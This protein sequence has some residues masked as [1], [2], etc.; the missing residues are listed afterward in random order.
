[1]PDPRE[2][3][4]LLATKSIDPAT[5]FGGEPEITPADVAAMLAP[6]T[7][8]QSRLLRVKY[9]GEAQDYHLLWSSWFIKLMDRGWSEGDGMVEKLAT[10]SLEEHISPNRCWACKGTKGAM[11]ANKH[12][13]CPICYGSGYKYVIHDMQD[14]WNGRL[15]WCR[16]E[17]QKLE[18]A[19]VDGM[20]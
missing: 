13:D 14:P 10:I 11:I 2:L 20:R 8:C 15:E 3:L 17:L 12:V 18:Q 5:T 19:A 7:Q 16:R 9:A 6:L 1:M 4:A